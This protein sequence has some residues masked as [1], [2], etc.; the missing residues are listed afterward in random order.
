VS[1]VL[2]IN[3]VQL[4]PRIIEPLIPA[5][6]PTY[7]DTRRVVVSYDGNRQ[8]ARNNAHWSCD[9]HNYKDGASLAV[10]K[11]DS[12]RF[13]KYFIGCL[14][15]QLFTVKHYKIKAGHD[16]RLLPTYSWGLASSGPVNS[17][18]SYRLF[19]TRQTTAN[20]LRNKHNQLDIHFTFT[21]TLLRSKCRRVSAITCPSSGDTTRTQI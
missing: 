8:M 19:A 20:K 10:I 2:F 18:S 9:F 4:L 14:Y 21:C 13:F 11:D 3:K 7:H 16:F 1:Y 6:Q 15:I 5:T 17:M 12:G